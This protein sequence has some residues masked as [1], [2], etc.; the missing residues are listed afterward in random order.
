M[1]DTEIQR[2]STALYWSLDANLSIAEI[3]GT[4]TPTAATA[5]NYTNDGLGTLLIQSIKFNAAKAKSRV[6]AKSFDGLTVNEVFADPHDSLS[7]TGK[8]KAAT[9][10]ATYAQ[11]LIPSE[12]STVVVVC[13]SDAQVAGTYY[14]VSAEKSAEI[15]GYAQVTLEL[16]TRPAA[17]ALIA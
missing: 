8:V 3:N 6:S 15:E 14:V 16:E 4:T 5:G 12:G 1:A 7:V 10:G 2:G 13:S 11:F 17:T 9:K